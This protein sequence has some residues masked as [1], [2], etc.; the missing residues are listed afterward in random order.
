MAD[1]AKILQNENTTLV[2][3]DTP[4]N[5][6][7]WADDLLLFSE[8][9]EG[10]NSILKQVN[11]HSLKNYLKINFDKTK[12]MIFNKT[13]RLLRNKFYIG[14]EKLENVRSYKYLG[15]VYLPPQEKSNLL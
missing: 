14:E 8:S 10:L 1:L 4:I 5:S 7:F 12:C 11:E 13:G 15:L 9:E 3:N 2:D 6:I